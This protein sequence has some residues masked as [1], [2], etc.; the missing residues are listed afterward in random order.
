V[1]ANFWLRSRKAS[2]WLKILLS[3]PNDP[4][5]RAEFISQRHAARRAIQQRVDHQVEAQNSGSRGIKW[6][7]CGIMLKKASRAVKK[8][9]LHY[10]GYAKHTQNLVTPGDVARGV[11]VIAD[12]AGNSAVFQRHEHRDRAATVAAGVV[13][14]ETG[15]ADVHRYHFK[16]GNLL[17]KSKRVNANLLGKPTVD[18]FV[19]GTPIPPGIRFLNKDL[20][21]LP[22]SARA[23]AIA[24]GEVRLFEPDATHL[25]VMKTCLRNGG[26]DA[27]EIL[28]A[29]CRGLFS[30]NMAAGQEASHGIPCLIRTT[31]RAEADQLHT[32]VG[33]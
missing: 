31:G 6:F 33:E 23:D 21:D 20:H 25:V 26:D 16:T 3:L 8:V 7:W 29:E 9:G 12:R 1:V 32:L 10:A 11:E 18:V 27:V 24:H 14:A 15:F 19:F 13:I 5:A 4:T 17:E 2:Y 22:D 28:L 30:I